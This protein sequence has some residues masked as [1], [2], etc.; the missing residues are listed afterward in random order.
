M[1][2][3]GFSFKQWYSNDFDALGRRP[4]KYTE[5]NYTQSIGDAFSLGVARRLF[6]GRLLGCADDEV[7][8][9]AVQGNYAAGN[10]TFFGKFTG[11]DA[12][13]ALEVTD[14]VGNNEPRFLFG[15]MTT[16]PWGD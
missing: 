7:I 8:D 11:T 13:E 14:D 16:F 2:A 3:G 6:V 10:F 1:N 12:S 15:V 5:A 4:R 9:Y